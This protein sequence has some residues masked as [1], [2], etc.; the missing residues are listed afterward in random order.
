VEVKGGGGTEVSCKC[1][2]NV[3]SIGLSGQVSSLSNF[4]TL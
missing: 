3:F 4:F 1:R 2:K